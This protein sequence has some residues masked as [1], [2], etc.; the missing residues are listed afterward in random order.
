V[1][2]DAEWRRLSE[3]GE[4]AAYAPQVAAKVMWATRDHAV[5]HQH[6][7][8]RV[9]TQAEWRAAAR[10]ALPGR[11]MQRQLLLQTL[12]AREKSPSWRRTG[13]SCICAVIRMVTRPKD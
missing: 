12:A 6:G 7:G 9:R 3:F 13:S 4:P 11:E 5:N 1:P 2:F 8:R 10:A